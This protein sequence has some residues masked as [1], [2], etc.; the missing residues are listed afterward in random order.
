MPNSLWMF[1]RAA[2]LRP[3]FVTKQRCLANIPDRIRLPSA[4]DSIPV[5]LRVSDDSMVS[6]KRLF[7]GDEAEPWP[8]PTIDEKFHEEEPWPLSPVAGPIHLLS[9][10][11][12]VRIDNG[13]LVIE[14]PSA[15][16]VE[17]PIELVSALHIHGWSTITVPASRNSSVRGRPSSGVGPLVTRSAGRRRCT[18]QPLRPGARARRGKDYQPE[19]P[20]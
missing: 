13:V 3:R 11:A 15:M 4:L 2:P 9:G 19:M 18:S 8:A 16:P 1:W 20:V 12:L 7:G 14:G 6:W 5:V 10:S 17:R